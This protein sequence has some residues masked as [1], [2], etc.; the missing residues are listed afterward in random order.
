MA[1]WSESDDLPTGS[2][3]GHDQDAALAE[4]SIRNPQEGLGWRLEVKAIPFLQPNYLKFNCL[5]ISYIGIM[6]SW[7]DGR[8]LNFE[9][10]F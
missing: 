1:G 3:D 8:I 5:T 7:N 2:G 10:G 9:V 6:G 4:K